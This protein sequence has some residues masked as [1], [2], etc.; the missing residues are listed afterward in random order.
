MYARVVVDTGATSPIESLTY[1]IPDGLA[2]RVRIG[3]CVLAPLASRQAIGY[4]IGFEETPSVENTRPIIAE[5]DSPIRLS[6]ETLDMAGWI[7]ARY[8]CPL[9]RVVTSIMP[10]MMHCHVQAR[11]EIIDPAISNLTPSEARLLEAIASRGEPPALESLYGQA[12]KAAIQRALRGLE[13]KGAAKRVWSIVTA[14]GKPRILQ[15]VRLAAGIRPDDQLLTSL[16]SKQAQ[17]L[18]MVIDLARD[19][20]ITEL[21]Q[22]FGASSSSISSLEKRGVL[23]RVEVTFRRQPSFAAVEQRGVTLS[24]DQQRVVDAITAATDSEGYSGHLI[25]G[26]TASGKTEVY[27]RLIEHALARGKSSLVLLPEIALTT[28]VM[29]I[30]K[31][32]FGSLVAVLHSA[33][34][35]GE[36]FDEWVRIEEGE[37]RIVLGARSAVF[38]PLKDL[39][40][41]IVDEEHETSYKQDIQPRYN[42]R[43]VAAYRAHKVGAPLVLGSATPSIE[44]YH[45]AQS[46]RFTLHNMLSRVENRPMP[47]VHVADLR[48]EYAQGKV[49]IFSGILEDGIRARLERGEQVMLLQNRRAYSTFLLCRDC[50]FVFRCPNCAVSLK[51]H[52][53]RKALSC[54]HCDYTRRAP[55]LCPKCESRRIKGFGI[56]T[57]RVEEEARKTF[58]NARILRM[59]RDTTS[60]KGSHGSILGAFRAGE[61]DILVGTQMIAKGLDFPNVTLVGIISADTSL[62]LPDFRASERTF[63]LVSQVAGR[64]GRGTR[65]GEVVIQT[66]DPDHYAIKC[67]VEHDYPAFYARE[68]SERQELKY[69][70]FGSLVNILSRDPDHEEARNRLVTLVTHLK[71][72]TMAA[73]KGIDILG[74]EPAVLSKLRGEYRWHLVL[75][76]RDREALVRL[77]RSA[78]DQAPALR[79]QL[80]VDVD[81]VSML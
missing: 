63:Q 47:T 53:A 36:R 64:S 69:P 26:V 71:A 16:T 52:S 59:D 61:A 49:T 70:P 38:A 18:R 19:V 39:G 48:E 30:F 15:G 34:S 60:R 55:D 27:L 21:T 75:R 72:A 20:T 74:P 67:A 57:E 9:P 73:R 50:G 4:V 33:L 13:S 58:P 56:G 81:P 41:V 6:Q 77:L 23:N 68:L 22:R 46:G 40:L 5:V 3:S 31:S 17:V 25:F 37:A 10:G 8:M 2:G 35:S 66:F 1:E 29:N 42:G 78:L 32:R 76:S 65:P 43:E 12:D 28:Q 79:R 62:N 14:T 24:A 44:T 45:L 80:T 51:F 54:H 7:A 11:V